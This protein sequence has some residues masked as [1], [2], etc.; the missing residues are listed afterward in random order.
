MVL[1]TAHD[2]SHF[3][4][5]LMLVSLIASFFMLDC[6]AARRPHCTSPCTH[7]CSRACRRPAWC[8]R[9]TTTK[10]TVRGVSMEWYC[11]TA[12]CFAAI[13]ALRVMWACGGNRLCAVVYVRSVRLLGCFHHGVSPAQ[14]T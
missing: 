14:Y 13:F 8:T 7:S 9:H 10:V 6:R 5:Q 1:T 12:A 4:N 3:T 2:C 11:R